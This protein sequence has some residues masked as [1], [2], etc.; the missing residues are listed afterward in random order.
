MGLRFVISHSLFVPGIVPYFLK[1]STMHLNVICYIL[2]SFSKLRVCVEGGGGGDGEEVVC[3]RGFSGS[4]GYSIADLEPS[5]AH[6][7]DK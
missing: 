7:V 6:F 2:P 4:P 1:S 3:I 5:G